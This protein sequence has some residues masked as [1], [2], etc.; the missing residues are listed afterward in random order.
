[1]TAADIYPETIRPLRRAE[2]EKMIELGMFDD[3]RVELLDG[4]LVAMSPQGSAHAEVLHRLSQRLSS[5]IGARGRVRLQSPLACGENDLPEPDIAVV[6]PADYLRAHPD[7]AS[8]VVEIAE[9]SLRKDR[10]K[11]R[12]YAAAGVRECWIFN[13]VDVVVEAFSA[14]AG[15]RFG[16][17]H[18]YRAPEV[19]RPVAFP[20]VEVPLA[21]IL[22]GLGPR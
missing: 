9:T 18:T 12:T 16:N 6:P 1:M 11:A 14:P 19:I 8:L 2:Y 13:L 3:E 21:Q 5:T 10:L 15:D 22:A 17:S 20:D 7:R 4:I